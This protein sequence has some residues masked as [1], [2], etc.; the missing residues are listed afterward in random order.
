MKLLGYHIEFLGASL[1]SR[2]T[3]VG[4]YS[5]PSKYVFDGRWFTFSPVP[6]VAFRF[7]VSRRPV[8]HRPDKYSGRS[9]DPVTDWISGE[10]WGDK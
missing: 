10:N 4:M 9:H 8:K 6:F 3:Y 5:A 2:A 1:D 7:V